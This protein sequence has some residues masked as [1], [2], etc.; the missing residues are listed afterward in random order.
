[1]GKAISFSISK[2][3]KYAREI[4]KEET[5]LT[6]EML[7]K[8][9]SL[10]VYP[11]EMLLTPSSDSWKNLKFKPY[12]FKARGVPIPCGALHP[13]MRFLIVLCIYQTLT[14]VIP[15]NKVRHE[16]RQIFFEMGFEEMPTNRYLRLIP[17][18]PLLSTFPNYKL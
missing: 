12:N 16:F 3:P 11:C 7:T 8:C 2:G 13:C 6:H 17:V 10:S 15:V 4:A 1:M 9:V 14:D 18:L 5:D